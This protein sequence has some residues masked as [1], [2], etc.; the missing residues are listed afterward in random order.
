MALL[1]F[2]FLVREGYFFGNSKGGERGMGK[3][4]SI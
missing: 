3:I 1:S 2:N 4:I